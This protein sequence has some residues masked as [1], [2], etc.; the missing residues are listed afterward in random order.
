MSRRSGSQKGAA[1]RAEVDATAAAAGS[2]DEFVLVTPTARAAHAAKVIAAAQAKLQPP[3]T[4]VEQMSAAVDPTRTKGSAE[5]EAEYESKR[6][7][8]Y[9]AELLGVDVPPV[10]PPGHVLVQ[11]VKEDKVTFWKLLMRRAENRPAL[12]QLYFT[13][14]LMVTVP[15]GMM[16]FAYYIA[17]PALVSDEES[18]LMWAGFAGVLGVNIVAIG[19]GLFA[20]YEKSDDD[21][22][23]EQVDSNS[24]AAMEEKRRRWTQWEKEQEAQESREDQER[25]KALRKLRDGD[26]EDDS[27][28]E[29][30]AEATEE[31]SSKVAAEGKPR[32][33][34]GKADSALAEEAAE[35]AA[36]PSRAGRSR[37]KKA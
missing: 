24:D 32:R 15:L 13:T 11:D 18:L 33:R 21:E 34:A 27:K 12:Q 37:S 2:D 30:T 20:Y 23:G 29:A 8:A 26:K 35:P 7:R 6:D 16:A 31:E 10:A 28:D 5:E 4:K 9:R 3:L 19:F 14:M 36:T 1:R 22:E 25:L 17:L